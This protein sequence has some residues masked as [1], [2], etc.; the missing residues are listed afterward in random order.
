M[1]RGASL[2]ATVSALIMLGDA[3]FGQQEAPTQPMAIRAPLMVAVPAIDGVVHEQEWRDAFRGAGMIA[4]QTQLYTFRRAIWWI[5]TDGRMIYAA[6][7]SQLPAQGELLTRIKPTKRDPFGLNMDDGVELWLAPNYTDGER[8]PYFQFM[9]NPL[10][11]ITDTMFDP[12]TSVPGQPWDG[13]WLFENGYRDGWW[14]SEIGIPVEQL[15]LNGDLHSFRF[16]LTRNWKQ[17]WECSSTEAA[18]G[19][20]KQVRTMSQFHLDQ[21]APRI[22]VL[23]FDRWMDGHWDLKLAVANAS[24]APMEVQVKMHAEAPVT[25]MAAQVGRE[26]VALAPG[27]RKEVRFERSLTTR[28]VWTGSVLVTS[29][30]GE[31]LWFSREWRFRTQ[32]PE[33]VWTTVVREKK[34]VT[35]YFGYSP[36]RSRIRAKVDFSGIKSP[37]KVRRVLLS[38]WPKRAERELKQVVAEE[39]QEHVAETAFD[40]PELPDGEYELRCTVE[41][42]EVLRDAAIGAFVRKRYEWEHN[43]LGISEQVVTPFTPLEVE[44]RSVKAVFRD[45][46]LNDLGLWEQVTSEGKPL[47]AHPMGLHAVVEGTAVPWETHGLEFAETEPSRVCARAEFAGAGLEAETRSCFDYDGLMTVELALR[48]NEGVTVDRLDLIVPVRAEEAY[49]MHAAGA[50]FGKNYGG[51]IPEGQGEVWSNT[52]AVTY[53]VPNQFVPYLWIG[54]TRRG[55]CWYADS[56]RD[57]VVAEDERELSLVREGD[58]VTIVLH[59]IAKP[60]RLD[61]PRQFTLHFQATPVKPRPADWRSWS[62]YRGVQRPGIRLVQIFGCCPYWGGITASGDVYPRDRDFSF[63]ERLVAINKRG[64]ITADDQ[65]FLEKWNR[66]YRQ[67]KHLDLYTRSTRYGFHIAPNADAMVPYTNIRAVRET[68]PEFRQ[69]QDEWI[70]ESYSSREWRD[71]DNSHIRIEPVRSHQDFALWYYKK[72]MELG[73]AGGIYWDLTFAMPNYNLL[74]SSGAHR[75]DDGTIRPGVGISSVRELMKRATVMYRLSGRLPYHVDHMSNNAIVPKQA[76]S[77]IQLDWELSYGT[78]DFQDRFS[79]DYILA[80]STG[81]Q[82]GTVPTVLTG[83]RGTQSE[84]ERT[85]LTRTLLGTTLVYELKG[86]FSFE[87]DRRLIGNTLG[88]IYDFGYGRADCQVYRYWEQPP[89]ETNRED[90]RCILFTRDGSLLL[91]A[92][93]FGDGGPCHVR[94]NTARLGLNG[95]RL[96]ARNAETGEQLVVEEGCVVFGLAKHD[97]IIAVTEPER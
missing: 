4:Y 25:G 31:D 7:R 37:E 54:G 50:G 97:F 9:G 63:I 44:G 59:L 75:A 74:S 34:A 24:Q 3:G 57:W 61:R 93:D 28:D 95:K 68:L 8:M 29:K 16:R 17:P 2:A 32:R 70:L 41:G 14:E 23:G 33:E 78:D 86:F 27:E 60:V 49:L 42:D 94:L 58:T 79:E 96:Q 69:F 51:K 43:A 6:V 65:R 26:L 76:F 36:Y 39:F 92:T 5:G 22:Q 72:M 15:R 91:I 77:T 55:V 83:V 53:G 73:F 1:I 19:G 46:R 30:D 56:D 48:Q 62:F 45:H 88:I 90:L 87:V 71:E 80:T 10:G 12:T 11:A 89:F 67:E 13:E 40:V 81:E 38:V 84:E 52:K 64:E 66:G 82:A 21:E 35:L 20:F 85:W 47:L 18:P